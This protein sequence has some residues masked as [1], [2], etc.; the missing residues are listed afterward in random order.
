[1][2]EGG[3]IDTGVQIIDASN[4]EDFAKKLAEMK[5]S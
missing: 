1:L 4:V 3:V 5:G 2:P